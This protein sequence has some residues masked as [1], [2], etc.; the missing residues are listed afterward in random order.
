MYVVL[1]VVC[2]MRTIKV[3]YYF[4]QIYNLSYIF[5]FPEPIFGSDQRTCC[6]QH[7]NYFIVVLWFKEEPVPSSD[8]R[9]LSWC[10][11][12]MDEPRCLPVKGRQFKGHSTHSSTIVDTMHDSDVFDLLINWSERPPINSGI[13]VVAWV[14]ASFF[15]ENVHIRSVQN[16]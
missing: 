10:V 12:T 5:N 3:I 8:N 1:C 7:D 15:L 14:H 11:N 2:Q 13:N 4:Y 16:F 6:L 9:V